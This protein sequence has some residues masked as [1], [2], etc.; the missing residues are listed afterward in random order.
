MTQPPGRR[1]ESAG[2]PGLKLAGYLLFL[3]IPLVLFLFVRHPAPIGASLLAGVVFMLG[4]RF[5]ARPYMERVRPVKCVWCNRWL[6]ER[7]EIAL[8]TGGGD[9]ALFACPRHEEPVR[10]FFGFVD[11]IRWV[12]RAGIFLPLLTLLAALLLAALTPS[13]AMLAHLPPVTAAFQLLVGLMVNLAAWGYRAARPAER[14][15]AV[16]PLHNFYL[17][18]I[19]GILWVFRLV[20]IWWIALGL[21]YFLRR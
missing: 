5:L 14:P 3:F 12:L 16:F 1:S 18:G 13:A 10:R 11:R 15:A 20:G 17:L 6:G 2:S 21:R 8:A 19:R 9:V 4:H 7:R